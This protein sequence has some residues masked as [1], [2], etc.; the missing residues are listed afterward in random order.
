MPVVGQLTLKQLRAFAAI[1]R[2]RKLSSAGEHLGV[3]QSAVSVLLQQIEVTLNTRLFDRS[4]RSLVPTRAADEA[5][6]AVE[7]IL[8]DVT[9]LES[10]FRDRAEFRQGRVHVA[11]TPA[12]GMS[13]MPATV[14]RF[15]QHFPQITL[16]IDDCAPDQFLP[17]IV[18]GQVDFGIG[19]PEDE[20]SSDIVTRTLVTDRLCLVCASTHPLAG[21][22]SVAWRELQGLPFIAGRSGYGVRRMIDRIA[23]QQ[24]LALSVVNEVSFLASIV[25]MVAS[26]LGVSIMPSALVLSQQ[27]P[28]LA[29]VPLIEPHVDRAVSVVAKRG[30]SLSPACEAFTALMAKSLRDV[31]QV[32][33]RRNDDIVEG[34]GTAP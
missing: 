15:R 20:S 21:R 32:G 19:T 26:G 16:V 25:W 10:G 11:I 9:E 27:F 31:A 2:L 12:V 4:T 8:S 3:T 22:K 1:Y 24:G 14:E 30:R 29:L 23:A 6:A 33:L 7:R 34:H 28:S 5:I 18:N 13:L 17:L